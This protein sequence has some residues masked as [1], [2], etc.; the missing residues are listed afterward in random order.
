MFFSH[1]EVF[2]HI[3]S[4]NLS[5]KSKLNWVAKL[6]AFKNRNMSI[7]FLIRRLNYTNQ[8]NSLKFENGTG[9]STT[10]KSIYIFGH[11]VASGFWDYVVLWDLLE[12]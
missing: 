11:R 10:L 1:S 12:M 9:L 4:K 8:Q 5:F 2:W 6:L 7:D 3:S